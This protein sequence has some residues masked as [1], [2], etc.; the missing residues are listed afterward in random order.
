MEDNGVQH[1]AQTT[2][3]SRDTHRKGLFGGEV[4]ADDGDGGHEQATE[5]QADA[6]RLRE[7]DLPVL[8][9]EGDHY[10]A[11]DDKEGTRNDEGTKI[12]SVVE[13]PGCN[14]DDEEQVGLDGADP[15]D[16]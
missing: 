2:A 15:G 11:E 16:I 1:T 8:V 13:G 12:A 4:G 6:D 5:A 10:H 14:A 3:G 7:H 9:A